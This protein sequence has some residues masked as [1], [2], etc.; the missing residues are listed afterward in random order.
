MKKINVN[1]EAC[2]GCGACVAIDP[3]HFEFNDNGLSQVINQEDLENTE[4][5]NAIESCPTAA[6]NIVD[7]PHTCE[8][9]SSECKSCDCDDK[10]E[11]EGNC[12][13]EEECTCTEC[14]CDCD[15]C[16]CHKEIE[17]N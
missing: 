4:L 16:D 11:S 7:A 10:C 5:T 14:E 3:T 8:C 1:E 17:E 15:C 6:I 13:C 9:D 2:I 12:S